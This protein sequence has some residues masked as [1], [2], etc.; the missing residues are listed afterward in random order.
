M[1][2]YKWLAMEKRNYPPSS[3]QALLIARPVSIM[4]INLMHGLYQELG[5]VSTATALRV[6]GKENQW[7]CEV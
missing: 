2:W 4:E 3:L 5:L 7:K 1:K 6:S